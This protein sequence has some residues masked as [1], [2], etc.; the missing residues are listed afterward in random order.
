MLFSCRGVKKSTFFKSKPSIKNLSDRKSDIVPNFAPLSAL[1]L[2]MKIEKQVRFSVALP[3][4][5]FK[6]AKQ[7]KTKNAFWS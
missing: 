3:N 4:I 6:L 1:N 5:F 2:K 7:P